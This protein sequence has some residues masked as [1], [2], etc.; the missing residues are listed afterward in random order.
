M[1]DECRCKVAQQQAVLG[2]G[3]GAAPRSQRIDY[4]CGAAVLQNGNRIV[5]KRAKIMVYT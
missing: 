3:A 2:V 5:T 1:N 4:F